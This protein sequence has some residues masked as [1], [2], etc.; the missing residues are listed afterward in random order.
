MKLCLT[1]GNMVLLSP[2]QRRVINYLLNTSAKSFAKNC[3]FAKLTNKLHVAHIC[4]TI[5]PQLLGAQGSFRAG[6]S[7]VEQTMAIRCI[8]DMC[9]VSKR[10][11]TI[12]FVDFNKAFDSID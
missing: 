1:N 8:L 3:A 10:M 6:Q 7:T 12:I 9:R 5:E 2:F 4:D 11:I